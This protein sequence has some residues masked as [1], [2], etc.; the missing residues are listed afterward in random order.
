M[1]TWGKSGWGSGIWGGGTVTPASILGNNA[2]I[3]L[4]RFPVPND[5]DV[6]EG[7]AV[8]I[9][10]F[11]SDGDIDSSSIVV[12]AN[13]DTVYS[14]GSYN[15]GYTGTV[16]TLAG[17]VVLLFVRDIGWGYRSTVQ[18]SISLVDVAGNSLA[19]TWDWQTREK[20]VCYTGLTPLPI[21]TQLLQPLTR[22][23]NLDVVRK[24]LLDNAITVRNAP[25]ADQ[26]AARVVYQLAFGTEISTILNQT[27]VRDSGALATRVCERNT[28]IAIDKALAPQIKRLEAGI[29][30][31]RT[32]GIA[33]PE[34]TDAFKSYKDSQQYNYRV[35]LAANLVLAAVAAEFYTG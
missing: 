12:T 6:P 2:P 22:F 1:T 31:L 7:S 18:I 20:P 19:D 32:A 8:R 34:Y 23:L 35:S 4:E 9:V 28:A 14:A 5:T 15:A 27:F 24:T 29:E 3:I 10:L 30:A 26:R 16:T 21:E 25:N 33:S 17:R 11:D 13:G